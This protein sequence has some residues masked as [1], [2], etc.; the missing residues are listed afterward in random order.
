MA[1]GVAIGIWAVDLAG[2]WQAPAHERGLDVRLQSMTVA[3]IHG[4]LDRV[5]E[6]ADWM[7]RRDAIASSAAAP[8]KALAKVRDTATASAAVASLAASC[9]SCHQARA[10][11]PAILKTF[12]S[13]GGRVVGHMRAHQ[14]ATDLLLAGLVAPDE[15]AWIRGARELQAAPLRPGDFPVS[16]RIG[17]LMADIEKSLHGEAARLERAAPSDRATAFGA[18]LVVCSQCH[19]RH[20]TLWE[21]PAR[22]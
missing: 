10:V 6:D 20:T 15:D 2:A 17:A 3:V 21:S 11:A 16:D 4:Q 18:L 1:R 9:G 13:A 8:A 12:E 19:T 22:R 5:R 14:N 7:G